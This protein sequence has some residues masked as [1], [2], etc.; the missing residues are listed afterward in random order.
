MQP[1]AAMWKPHPQPLRTNVMNAVVGCGLID[2]IGEA[3][4]LIE[5]ND[6]STLQVSSN[7]NLNM[8]KTPPLAAFNCWKW[9]HTPTIFVKERKSQTGRGGFMHTRPDSDVQRLNPQ[10]PNTTPRILNY[11]GGRPHLT[12][13]PGI[14]N[15]WVRVVPDVQY[16]NPKC[17]DGGYIHKKGLVLYGH[18]RGLGSVV[19]TGQRPRP[20]RP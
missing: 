14:Q 7:D 12:P 11:T 15:I 6:A 2:E 20:Q 4:A 1:H 17:V 13:H 3:C 18:P 5:N 8:D 19:R 9:K 10:I 16:K